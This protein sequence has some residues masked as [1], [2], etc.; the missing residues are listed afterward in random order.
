MDI[1]RKSVNQSPILAEVEGAEYELLLN[2]IKRLTN[3]W[4]K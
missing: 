4:T 3:T 2:M 1:S